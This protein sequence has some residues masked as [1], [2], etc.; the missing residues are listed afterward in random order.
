MSAQM[1][2]TALVIF[3]AVVFGLVTYVSVFTP[4]AWHW[5]GANLQVHVQYVAYVEQVSGKPIWNGLGFGWSKLDLFLPGLWRKHS[6][7]YL[8]GPQSTTQ[9][10]I[11]GV[12]SRGV[13][14]QLVRQDSRGG[15]FNFDKIIFATPGAPVRVDISKDIY[16]TACFEP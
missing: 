11:V 12:S 14:V 8:N 7:G 2:K 1:R 9:A 10:R 5:S 15:T 13:S 16:V 6:G 4:V 3:A